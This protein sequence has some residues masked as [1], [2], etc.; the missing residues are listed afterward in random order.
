MRKIID[1]I[2]R[3]KKMQLI[4]F[5]FII[6]PFLIYVL[7]IISMVWIPNFIALLKILYLFVAF[8]FLVSWLIDKYNNTKLKLY[9]ALVAILLST[10][11]LLSYPARNFLIRKTEAQVVKIGQ[12]IEKY[13]LQTGKY[14]ENFDDDF[15][16]DVPKKSFIG[17]NIS[18]DIGWRD[19]IKDTTCYIEYRSFYGY[20]AIYNINTKHL[21]YHD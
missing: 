19:G 4:Y 8:V 9:T 6:S 16:M 1:K 12:S 14:P 17:T 2:V 10:Y 20:F 3:P 21:S 13:K 18:V 11:A 7:Y 5:S 15:F